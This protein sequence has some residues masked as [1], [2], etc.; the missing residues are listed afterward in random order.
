MAAAPSGRSRLHLR[1]GDTNCGSQSARAHPGSSRCPVAAPGSRRPS[2]RGS[3]SGSSSS[4]RWYCR[5]RENRW[6]PKA[7]NCPVRCVVENAGAGRGVFV[8]VAQIEDVLHVGGHTG[9]LAPGQIAVPGE[10][11]R[12]LAP[13]GGEIGIAVHAHRRQPAEVVVGI[14]LQRQTHS[15][16]LGVSFGDPGLFPGSRPSAGTSIPARTAIMPITTSNSTSVNAPQQA[17]GQAQSEEA[18]PA[19]PNG[20]VFMVLRTVRIVI[21]FEPTSSRNLPHQRV[22]PGTAFGVGSPG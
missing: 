21:P 11:H 17:W 14:H 16:E 20:S 19:R 4:C 12:E 6:A 13:V 15:I 9:P 18:P 22:L 8:G 10:F 3:P 7:G 1:T 5:T 2:A